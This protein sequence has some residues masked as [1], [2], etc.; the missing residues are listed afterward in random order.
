MKKK[1]IALSLSFMLVACATFGITFA[2]LTSETGKI[3]NTFTVG[4]VSIKLY[5]EINE[6]Y[7]QDV[8]ATNSE[9][10]WTTISE[11]ATASGY[12]IIPGTSEHKAPYVKVETGSEKCYVYIAVLNEFNGIKVGPTNAKVDAVTY[13]YDTTKWTEVT[14]TTIPANVKLY[15]YRTTCTAGNS[16]AALFNEIVYS[17]KIAKSDVTSLTGKTI[18]IKA[19]AIQ[20]SNLAEGSSTG[21]TVA[22]TYAV[23]WV[24]ST[25]GFGSAS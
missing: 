13:S 23:N 14:D 3:T 7:I 10:V 16:T 18:Q 15:A 11:G 20:S 5:E 2:W 6:L 24:K 19:F 9:D 12:K 4:D 1:I 25:D 21:A 8:W 17:E 22:N